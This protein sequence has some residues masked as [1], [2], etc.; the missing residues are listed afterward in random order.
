MMLLTP[1]SNESKIFRSTLQGQSFVNIVLGGATPEGSK[2][3]ANE[4]FALRIAS[5]IISEVASPNFF[6]SAFE[7][8]RAINMSAPD[9]FS[10][11]SCISIS[12]LEVLFLQGY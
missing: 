7:L 5:V 4:L 3:S 11:T 6:C 9:K 10:L 1:P 12:T 2:K 8:D